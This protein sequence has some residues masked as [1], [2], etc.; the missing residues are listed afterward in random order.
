MRKN[1]V[2]TLILLL[3]GLLM[4]GVSYSPSSKYTSV[5]D[6]PK[7]DTKSESAPG[8]IGGRVILSPTC[9]VERIPPDPNCT[10]RG[11][12]TEIFIQ[13]K[14]NNKI[15]KNIQSDMNGY[16]NAKLSPG[17]YILE[18]QGKMPFPSCS[19]VD[20]SVVAEKSIEIEIPCDTGIR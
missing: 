16:F 8:S 19:P 7:T 9:P 1:I 3:T 13:N 12:Q 18:A 5:N 11:F 17:T 6:T 15:I 10:P 4:L 20:I 2:P 14:S